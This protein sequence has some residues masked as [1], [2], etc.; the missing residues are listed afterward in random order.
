MDN[1]PFLDADIVVLSPKQYESYTD[2]TK[3]IVLDMSKD[4]YL[5]WLNA[6]FERGKDSKFVSSIL[7]NRE[8]G[9]Q[10][11]LSIIGKGQIGKS[12][13]LLNLLLWF[14]QTTSFTPYLT[15]DLNEYLNR[16]SASK[17]KLLALEEAERS[18]RSHTLSNYAELSNV[19]IDFYET[20]PYLQNSLILSQPSLRLLKFLKAKMDYVLV[21]ARRGVSRIYKV[22]TNLTLE[23]VYFARTK[24]V[25]YSYPLCI[26]IYREY[27]SYSYKKKSELLNSDKS[28][29]Q[30][31]LTQRDNPYS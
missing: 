7:H 10:T 30:K 1:P 21:M 6:K 8:F 17:K 15:Y 3:K 14:N 28:T 13:L 4:D 24:E 18:L 9:Y 27:E 31:F 19:I 22:N 16:A 25:F 5:N 23:K 11:F 26:D 29:I 12:V 20:S 2:K